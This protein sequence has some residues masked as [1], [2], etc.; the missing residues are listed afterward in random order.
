MF[1]L[2]RIQAFTRIIDSVNA[3]ISAYTSYTY[4]TL[5]DL[6]IHPENG[7][8]AFASSL[9]GWGFTL[10][11]FAARYSKKFGVRQ[12]KLM[13]K[14]WGENYFDSKAG[15]WTNKNTDVEGEPL[16][17]A[18]NVFV[19]DPIYRLY[20]ATMHFKSKDQVAALLQ[21]LNIQL[22]PEEKALEGEQLLKVVMHRF[23]PCRDAVLEMACIHL[24]S[25]VTAQ[26]YR[27]SNLYQGPLNDACADGIRNCDSLAPL[28]VYVFKIMPMPDKD[29]FYAL[30]RVFSGTARADQK[31]RIMGPNYPPNSKDD[32]GMEFI[33]KVMLLTDCAL[34]STRGCSAG[35]IIG[36]VGIGNYSVKPSVIAPRKWLTN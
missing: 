28:M 4:D 22:N 1:L 27:V 18:F 6:Q 33:Q 35:N 36:L 24:P 2:Y 5:G 30:G 25:P 21:K 29:G 13:E 8:V 14:L 9:H 19:L 26:S 16:E 32:L 15:Q 31:V 23:L 17:R 20:D 7:S 11:Q 34:E 10:R 3:T 12:D